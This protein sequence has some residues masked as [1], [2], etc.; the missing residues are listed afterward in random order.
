MSKQT[1]K[2][3][4][5]IAYSPIVDRPRLTW[6]GGA[7]VALWVAP[8]V[9][10]YEYTPPPSHGGRTPWPRV[11]APD[12]QQYSYRDYGNRVGFWRMTELLDEYEV[13]AT[14]SL[15]IGV[16]DHYPE[17]TEAMASRDWDFM[18]HGLYNTRYIYEYSADDERAFYEDTIESLRHHTGKQLKG[19]LGPAISG[20]EQTPDLMAEAGLIYHADWVH[21]D[22][23]VPIAVRSGR[24][25]SVPYSYELNDA[26][27]FVHHHDG[28]YFAEI[29]KAQF[30]RLYAEGERT[31]MVMCI[32]LHPFLIGQPHLI[33][34]LRDVFDHIRSHDE[35]W[36]TTADDI[37]EFYLKNNYDQAVAG[38]FDA[39]S[40]A[41]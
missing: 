26:P 24:L 21:D 6:P 14:V 17:I 8:N 2:P 15:N 28:A 32:A 16:L 12:V 29:C 38:A 35:V 7:R 20:T 25:V 27:L 11:P 40:S 5:R 22:Q 10:H 41:L 30:D 13:R 31:G 23:P 19:M 3:R 1:L 18:S 34:H 36:W 33:G 4:E 9:E 39:V 37:A